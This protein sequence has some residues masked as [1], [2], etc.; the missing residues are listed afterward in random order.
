MNRKLYI[1]ITSVYLENPQK[2]MSALHTQGYKTSTVKKKATAS[3]LLGLVTLAYISEFF[4]YWGVQRDPV[5]FLYPPSPTL[6]GI[7]SNAKLG[8]PV[9]PSV[10]LYI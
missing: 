4:Q 2:K 5:G 8:L 1:N 3:A 7:L 6:V 9:S 10:I